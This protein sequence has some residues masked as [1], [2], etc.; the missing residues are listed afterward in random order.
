MRLRT[1]IR[2]SIL[3]PRRA[4]FL[5]AVTVSGLPTIKTEPTR[6][7]GYCVLSVAGHTELDP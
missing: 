1:G 3:K 5:I 6:F 7:R 2:L 4:A